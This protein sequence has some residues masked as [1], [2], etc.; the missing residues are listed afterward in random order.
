[1]IVATVLVGVTNYNIQEKAA[2][3]GIGGSARLLPWY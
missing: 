1:V 2:I 3:A